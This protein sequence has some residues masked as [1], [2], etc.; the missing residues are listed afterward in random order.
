M[1]LILRA[2]KD[3]A[4]I[5]IYDGIGQDFWGDGV[6][7]KSFD[8][9]LKA[10]GAPKTINVRINSGGGN[11]FDGIAI[12]NALARHSAR[13]VVHVDGLAAS[14]A[15]V[16]AMAGDE[17]LMGDG[18]FMMVHNAWSFAIGNA[19]EMR[20]T[21]DLLDSV[22]GQIADIYV[23]RS[24]QNAK[25]VKA[26]MDAETWMDADEAVKKGFADGRDKDAV[27]T[28]ASIDARAFR[29]LPPALAARMHDSVLHFDSRQAPASP[30]PRRAALM[31]R[32]AASRR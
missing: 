30:G 12:Y 5:L 3:D 14:I 13:K 6:T 1:P 25:A 15:S 8:K 22:S 24:G 23:N 31:E 4:E 32:V 21:A 18:T 9:E 20:R 2:A 27:R 28:A 17:I 11:V 26:L 10:L 19:A 16:I 7:A 29:N